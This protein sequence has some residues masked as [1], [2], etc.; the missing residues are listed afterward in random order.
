METGTECSV[1]FKETWGPLINILLV[2]RRMEGI[3]KFCTERM[4]LLFIYMTQQLCKAYSEA[5]L[6]NKLFLFFSAIH[7][8]PTSLL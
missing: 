4:S 5:M 6:K 2:V 3:Y 8:I 1:F 7:N